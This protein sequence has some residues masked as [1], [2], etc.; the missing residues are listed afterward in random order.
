MQ[1]P[2]RIIDSR[3]SNRQ[4]FDMTVGNQPTHALFYLKKGSFFIEADGMKREEIKEGDCLILPSYV[5]FKR[6]IIEPIEFLFI[7]FTN[8]ES[9][10]YTFALPYGK[11]TFSSD[12]VKT[13]FCDNIEKIE[14]SLMHDSLISA[15]YREHLFFDVL[16]AVAECPYGDA[17]SSERYPSR[18]PLLLSA[19]DYIRANVGRK[20]RIDDVCKG[21]GTN[22]STLHFHFRRE[23][24]TSVNQFIILE[25]MKKARALLIGT[26]YSI[27]DIAARCGFDNV[28]YFS[29]S[30]KKA[31]GIS[32]LRYRGGLFD[33]TAT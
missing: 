10:P 24:G 1:F 6:S 19:I 14:E 7:K 30:F 23:L 21:V 29:N 4:E 27:S 31:Y 26:T 15:G 2:Y 12:E 17:F 3:I 5:H 16:F 20:I 33:A 9:C 8:N 28:Y 11:I 22:A 18:D 13:R 32:P 25:K